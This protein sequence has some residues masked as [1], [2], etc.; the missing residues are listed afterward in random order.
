[1]RVH[2]A[3][4][5][6]LTWGIAVAIFLA[7]PFQLE[8]RRFLFSGVVLMISFIAV[9]CLAALIASPPLPERRT[10]FGQ[11]VDFSLLD[12]L[13]SVVAAIACVAQIFDILTGNVLDLQA[14]FLDRNERSVGVLTGSAT[15]GS[16]AFQVGFLTYPAG[17][18]AIAREILFRRTIDPVR[19][20]L[21]GALPVALAAVAMG[22]RGPILYGLILVATCYRLRR[23]LF[24]SAV[25]AKGSN[26]GVKRFAT[27]VIAVLVGGVA[28]NY[29]V[30]VFIARAEVAGGVEAMQNVAAL[31]WGVSFDGPGSE[32]LR[33]IVGEGN[34]Y[35]LYVFIWYGVQGIVMSNTIFADYDGGMTF[36]I[37]GLDLGSAIARR[38]DPQFVAD[39]FA[40]L[41]DINTYGFLPSAFGSLYVDFGYFALIPCA[42]WGYFSGVAYRKIHHSPDPRWF[43]AGPFISLGIVFSLINTPLGFG[44]G[45]MTHI[46]LLI[47]CFMVRP[48]GA[49]ATRTALT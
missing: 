43:L 47:A 23:Q 1:M 7:L 26:D 13:L 34:S 19:L 18:V 3:F 44:N 5:M 10:Q 35:L 32:T 28:M 25:V 46:W 41:L 38:I 22:G 17:F 45:L 29:F 20:A 9:F 33:A 39:R 14:A 12:R 37:Y 36:G 49:R 42:L 31:N 40:V 27:V 4:T 11:T 6:L 48:V 2:P 24:P 21:V 8:T 16:L 30:E 15:G